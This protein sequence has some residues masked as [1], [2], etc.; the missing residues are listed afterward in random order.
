MAAVNVPASV[1]Q[2]GRCIGAKNHPQIYPTADTGLYGRTN[3]TPEATHLMYD[4]WWDTL[5]RSA[6]RLEQKHITAS[7]RNAAAQFPFPAASRVP[8][9]A[10]A[11]PGGVHR[12]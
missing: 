3:C 5:L 12:V 10:R 1:P 7:E 8:S 4:A 6:V 11:R 2:A 9:P